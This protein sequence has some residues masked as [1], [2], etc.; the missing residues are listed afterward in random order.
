M[1][2][3]TVKEQEAIFQRARP[4]MEKIL[5]EIRDDDLVD[6]FTALTLM[7]AQVTVRMGKTTEEALELINNNFPI[8]VTMWVNAYF[9]AK[10][11]NIC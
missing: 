2:D 8:M 6:Q 1:V 9:E 4:I 11:P 10:E 5:L 7:L 3:K